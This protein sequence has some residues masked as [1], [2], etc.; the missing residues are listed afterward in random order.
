MKSHIKGFGQFISES[1]LVEE[2]SDIATSSIET[3][4][5]RHIAGR[6]SRMKANM[7]KIDINIADINGKINGVTDGIAQYLI[8]ELKTKTVPNMLSGKG[9]YTF[10][11]SAFIKLSGLVDTQLNK[12]GGGMRWVI[13]QALPSE[14]EFR[15]EFNRSDEFNK[16][17][18]MFKSLIDFPM[19]IGLNVSGKNP[20]EDN[21][22]KFDDQMDAYLEKNKDIIKGIVLDK[23]AFFIYRK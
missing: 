1:R 15:D 12:F 6:V 20:E 18:S 19:A 13:R 11:E 16:Y 10:A 2:T 7:P 21:V 23:L 3:E 14:A 8:S 22:F 5:M 17:F 9:G 4:L